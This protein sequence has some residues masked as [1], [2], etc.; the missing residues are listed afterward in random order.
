L[1]A[2]LLALA[3]LLIPH[4]LVAQ[5]AGTVRRQ[6]VSVTIDRLNAFLIGFEKHPLQ[7]IAGDDLE[8][9]FTKKF[10]RNTDESISIR[11]VRIDPWNRA[12]GI[13]I[14][15]FGVSNGTTLVLQGKSE[16]LPMIHF[17]VNHPDHQESYTLGGGRARD[18]GIGAISC[19]RRAGWSGVG[20]CA[21][22]IGGTGWIDEPRGDGRRYFAEGGAR[23][24][25]GPAGAEMFFRLAYHRLENP[26]PHN[27]VT[28]PL[29]V[30]GVLTF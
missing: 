10:Y 8:F 15:P 11:D 18:L 7:Q 16:T 26:E 20:A 13:M 19:Q 22:I 2:A 5:P 4:H 6:F 28:V 9:D 1:R 30:R 23:I 25:V 12:V 21:F 3:L 24:S 14:Y 17:V 29:G 27:F